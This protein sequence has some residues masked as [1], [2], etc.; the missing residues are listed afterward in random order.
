MT[1]C[2]FIL[3]TRNSQ[4]ESWGGEYSTSKFSSGLFNSATF[5]SDMLNSI[6]IKSHVVEVVDGNA[7]NAELHK[8]KPEIVFLE[9]IWVDPAKLEELTNLHPST[10]FIV[11]IHSNTPFISNEGIAMDWCYRYL[12]AGITIAP[13]SKKMEKEFK[14]LID[15]GS[16]IYLPNYYE[17]MYNKVHRDKH[18]DILDVGCFGAVRPLK[19]Q[20][21]QAMAAIEVAKTLNKQL[22]FHINTARVENNGNNVLKNIR[23]LFA[24]L[25]SK[26]FSL[27]EHNWL[28]HNEFLQLVQSMD[29][30][31]QVSFSETFNI[32]SADYASQRVPIVASKEI[33]WIN[34]VS[35]ADPTDIDTIVHKMIKGLKYSED[36]AELNLINLISWNNISRKTWSD[37][38]NS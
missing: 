35:I 24:N 17:I 20:L 36:V 6:D 33:E 18:P 38:I 3:K 25:D 1:K 7:I 14:S 28:P 4:T 13:N 21:I 16:V 26:R 2:L 8:F 15:N 11:R 31:L 12:K 32:V 30:G 9:A 10:K 29:I 22:N 5:V 37:F 23:S 19:N 34:N 27:V